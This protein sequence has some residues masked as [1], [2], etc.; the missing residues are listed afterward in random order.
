MAKLDTDKTEGYLNPKQIEYYQGEGFDTDIDF[1]SNEDFVTEKNRIINSYKSKTISSTEMVQQLS[2]LENSYRSYLAMSVTGGGEPIQV[3]ADRPPEQVK[4]IENLKKKKDAEIDTLFNEVIWP[5]LAANMN[6]MTFKEART[7]LLTENFGDV[8]INKILE[9]RPNLKDSVA[10]YMINKLAPEGVFDRGEKYSNAEMIKIVE[11]NN[12]NIKSYK[13]KV[14]DLLKEVGGLPEIYTGKANRETGNYETR[15]NYS[16]DF[17][18]ENIDMTQAKALFNNINNKNKEW[19]A[20]ALKDREAALA[21]WEKAEDEFVGR[22]P[23][24]GDFG[25][26]G[27]GGEGKGPV[28]NPLV[29]FVTELTT[30]LFYDWWVPDHEEIWHNYKLLY[31]EKEGG[32]GSKE[33]D[34][35]LNEVAW[36]MENVEAGPQ[37]EGYE[38]FEQAEER[39]NEL[40]KEIQQ[41]TDIIEQSNY[42]ELLEYV[43]PSYLKEEFLSK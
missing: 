25:A 42:D 36:H 2:E 11:D 20:N 9:L 35:L 12:A 38:K 32:F 41:K 26:L 37:G 39:L 29:A 1:Y 13:R 23:I 15:T 3:T 30:G 4:A 40:A 18:A 28:W 5:K 24:V 8:P 16:F 43:S 27:I 21:K 17:F 7:Y 33:L 31:N 34:R 6:E 22:W 10:T 14:Y 19:V